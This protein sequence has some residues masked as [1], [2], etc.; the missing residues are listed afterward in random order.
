[1][2]IRI[3]MVSLEEYHVVFLQRRLLD[4]YQNIYGISR[5]VSCCV[6]AEKAA[7]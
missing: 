5:R 4:E 2:S 6:L 3:S 7:G 1:M